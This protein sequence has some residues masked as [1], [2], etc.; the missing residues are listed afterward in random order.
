MELL[1]MDEDMICECTMRI[2]SPKDGCLSFWKNG[3]CN[4]RKTTGFIPY[5]IKEDF[6]KDYEIVVLDVK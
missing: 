2:C 5:Y 1:R 3:K 6:K 4:H